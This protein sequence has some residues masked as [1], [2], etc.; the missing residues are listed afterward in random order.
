MRIS[1]IAPSRHK[2][3]RWLIWL[4]D[5]SLLRVGEAEMLDFSLH[6]GLELDDAAADRLLAAARKGRL[7]EKALALL[8]ARPMSRREL[9]DRLTACPRD[10]EKPPLADEAQAAE[11]ADWL[12]RLGLLN[13]AEYARTVVRHYSAKGY[14]PYKVRDELYRRGVARELWEDALAETADPCAA[15]DAFLRQKLKDAPTDRRELKKASD[16]LARRGYHWSDISEGL[17]R[18]GGDIEE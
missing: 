5:G 10:R 2:D 15:I 1:K 11:T 9:I 16:A 4:E 14:G 17:R 3:G 13:D 18:W 6:A 7:R 8:T 12:E